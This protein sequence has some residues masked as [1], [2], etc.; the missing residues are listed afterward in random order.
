MLGLWASLEDLHSIL[1]RAGIFRRR[2]SRMNAGDIS[3]LLHKQ[4]GNFS[5]KATST[6]GFCVKIYE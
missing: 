6:S 2:I 5:K 4:V 3:R 1:E